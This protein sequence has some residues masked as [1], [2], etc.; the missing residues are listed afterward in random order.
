MNALQEDLDNQTHL[1]NELEEAMETVE[2]IG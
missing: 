2:K 1:L